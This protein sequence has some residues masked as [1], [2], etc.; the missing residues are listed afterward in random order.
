MFYSHSAYIQNHLSHVKDK[1]RTLLSTAGVLASLYNLTKSVPDPS[2]R[3]VCK[4]GPHL[5]LPKVFSEISK[6]QLHIIDYE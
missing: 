3:L 2:H 5:L 1:P 6:T 4:Y